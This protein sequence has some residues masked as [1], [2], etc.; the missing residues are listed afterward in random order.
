MNIAWNKMTAIQI[1]QLLKFRPELRRD[2][3]T[4]IKNNSQRDK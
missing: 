3:D 4:K 2:Y 1:A